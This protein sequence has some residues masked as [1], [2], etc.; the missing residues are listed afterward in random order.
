MYANIARVGNSQRIQILIIFGFYVFNNKGATGVAVLKK[1]AI[2][3][4]RHA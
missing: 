3:G 4:H 2:T 1:S